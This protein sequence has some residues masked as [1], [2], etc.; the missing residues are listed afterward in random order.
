MFHFAIHNSNKIRVALSGACIMGQVL[1]KE[2]R[3]LH[4]WQ[5]RNDICPFSVLTGLS[6]IPVFRECVG[7]HLALLLCRFTRRWGDRHRTG[8]G[9]GD[10][11]LS[12]REDEYREKKGSEQ[13]WAVREYIGKERGL[14]RVCCAPY[15]HI[16]SRYRGM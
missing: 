13:L 12:L 15:I 14:S 3:I 5:N 10:P 4:M 2:F 16:P 9:R 1:L 11:V 8:M 7:E 6:L